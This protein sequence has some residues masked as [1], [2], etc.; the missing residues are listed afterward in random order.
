MDTRGSAPARDSRRELERLLDDWRAAERG[1]AGIDPDGTAHHIAT[2]RV[3]AAKVAYQVG[4]NRERDGIDGRW[5]IEDLPAFGK[6]DPIPHLE[7][8][9][10]ERS[11]P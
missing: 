8:D 9:A 6:P 1:L 3:D 2:D 7:S 10:P 11:R 5:K 4:A